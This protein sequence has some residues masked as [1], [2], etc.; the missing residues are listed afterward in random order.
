MGEKKHSIIGW[1]S[2]VIVI[3]VIV[4][5]LLAFHSYA[6]HAGGI[7]SSSFDG[8]LEIERVACKDCEIGDEF[9][10]LPIA[11]IMD[12]RQQFNGIRERAGDSKTLLQILFDDVTAIY[13]TNGFYFEFDYTHRPRERVFEAMPPSNWSVSKEPGSDVDS[14][15]PEVFQKVAELLDGRQA[16]MVLLYTDDFFANADFAFGRH[17]M[18]TSGAFSDLLN[19]YSVAVVGFR[20]PFRTS[21]EPQRPMYIV[22]FSRKASCI[23]E[24]FDSL[25]ERIDRL[26]E[27]LGNS[28]VPEINIAW[29][30]PDK[31]FVT[32]EIEI[33]PNEN[34][35]MQLI[36]DDSGPGGFRPTRDALNYE[37]L[38]FSV[39]LT[40][41][42]SSFWTR[43]AGSYTL[44]RRVQLWYQTD[45]DSF[46]YRFLCDIINV[47]TSVIQREITMSA[48]LLREL[49]EDFVGIDVITDEIKIPTEILRYLS[50][51][52]RHQRFKIRITYTPVLN[53][54][55]RLA[56]VQDWAVDHTLREDGRPSLNIDAL[57]RHNRQ[58]IEYI[59]NA[60]MAGNGVAWRNMKDHENM[61]IVRRELR[62][63][64][65]TLW[66]NRL[67]NTS[68]FPKPDVI[69]EASETDVYILLPWQ[70]PRQ[71]I[72]E[73]R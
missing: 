10:D 59:A 6:S 49:P 50:G 64:T 4:G 18:E 71:L 25:F 61:G 62:E 38:T 58:T 43:M 29:N 20:V 1:G 35:T 56:W 68:N 8:M 26:Y 66:L 67:I 16:R 44:E 15:M 60:E 5:G 51:R 57:L 2:T 53:H 9:D 69:F 65:H 19:D 72:G 45:E 55:N 21:Q 54:Q 23:T 13:N 47:D 34:D 70:L 27:E 12:A 52:S 36:N 40:R 33:K 31:R 41:V 7:A 24:H 39:Q 32:Y 73:Y 3:L 17:F 28:E 46:G 42:E 11:V 63:T 14:V 22:A 30:R 37:Y 48:A